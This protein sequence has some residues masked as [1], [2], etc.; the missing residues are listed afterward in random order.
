MMSPMM[1]ETVM[2]ARKIFVSW[3]SSR[4]WVTAL[5]LLVVNPVHSGEYQCVSSCHYND[6]KI[7]QLRLGIMIFIGQTVA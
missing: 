5:L 4:L 6:G 1:K 7:T 2:A 3:N